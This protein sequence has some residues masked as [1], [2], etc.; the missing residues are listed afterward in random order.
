M[1][2]HPL[3]LNIYSLLLIVIECACLFQGFDIFILGDQN[4]S[5]FNLNIFFSGSAWDVVVVQLL[6]QPL[7]TLHYAG[8]L[9]DSNG[10]S[11]CGA[12]HMLMSNF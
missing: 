5:V 10:I 12:Y 7:L 8:V 3:L 2:M 11:L 4:K 9:G 1:F 6:F